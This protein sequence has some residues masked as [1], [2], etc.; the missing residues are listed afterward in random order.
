VLPT[1][2]TI[3]PHSV[4]FAD[5][6]K[7][8]LMLIAALNKCPDFDQR[9]IISKDDGEFA[10]IGSDVKSIFG[11]FKAAK[12]LAK[13]VT[14][15]IS[16]L[17]GDLFG[18]KANGADLMH[19]H[20]TSLFEQVPGDSI[21]E[22]VF[23]FI[24]MHP[25]CTLPDVLIFLR[26]YVPPDEEKAGPILKDASGRIW[27]PDEIDDWLASRSIQRGSDFLRVSAPPSPTKSIASRSASARPSLR[28]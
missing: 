1:V 8:N 4:K 12:S 24:R 26:D 3:L 5:P 20:L 16:S 17:F 14:G 15:G 21:F 28:S 6:E 2:Q 13:T 19:R 25:G 10:S 9:R 11:G 18:Q 23:Q 7:L 22:V 27:T